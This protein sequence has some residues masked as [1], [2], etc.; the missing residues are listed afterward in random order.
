MLL[1]LSRKLCISILGILGR[2]GQGTIYKFMVLFALLHSASHA[3]L[4]NIKIALTINNPN[5]FLI[6]II[7]KIDKIALGNTLTMMLLQNGQIIADGSSNA[8]RL[9]AHIS[10]LDIHCMFL[11][12]LVKHTTDNDTKNHQHP[13]KAQHQLESNFILPRPSHGFTSKR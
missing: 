2:N 8:L 4:I 13:G 1:D 7:D 12:K 3:L 11:K 9:G 10:L 6:Q 5:D